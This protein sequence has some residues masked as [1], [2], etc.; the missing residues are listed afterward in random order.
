MA[1]P[2][3]YFRELVE[4]E[5]ISLAFDRDLNANGFSAVIDLQRLDADTLT[6]AIEFYSKSRIPVNKKGIVLQSVPYK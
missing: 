5:L 1:E 2:E 6:V 4:D 3:V